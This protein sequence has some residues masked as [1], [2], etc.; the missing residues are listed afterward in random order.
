MD[1]N[2]FL[3]VT[4]IVVL[5]ICFFSFMIMP[6]ITRKTLLFGVRIPSDVIDS[7]DAKSLKARYFRV[8]ILGTVLL[9][10]VCIV[11]YFIKPDFTIFTTMYLPLVYIL[12]YIIAFVP[13]WKRAL[14]LK[15]ERGWVAENVVLT[16]THASHTRGNL[17]ALPWAWYFISVA[18]IIVTF[19]IGVVRYP[20]LG[21]MIATRFNE[22]F[23]AIEW[24]E[25]TWLNLLMLPLFN[26]AFL[27]LMVAVAISV[28]K[29]KLQ[30]DSTKPRLSFAQH[31]VYRRRIGHSLG[32]ITLTIAL[33]LSLVWLPTVYPDVALFNA[34]FF[35]VTVALISIPTIVI[36]VVMFKTGQGGSK[37]KLKIDEDEAKNQEID[38]EKVATLECDDMYWKFGTFYYNPEDPALIVEDRFG[39]NIGFNYARLPAKILIGVVVVGLVVLYGFVTAM[40][41]SG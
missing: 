28:E 11:Q 21:D 15:K 20:E 22:S 7:D 29:A 31:R 30:I 38:I 4:N 40:L 12:I 19:I 26:L 27:A 6:N 35:W 39:T 17:S 3:F 10:V 14:E 34:T 8:C 1:I 23:E 18:M 24:A 32:F 33:M 37:V 16:D 13:N 5:I 25:K 2:I 41:L 36:I 9:L